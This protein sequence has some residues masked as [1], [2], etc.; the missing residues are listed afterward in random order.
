MRQRLLISAAILLIYGSSL[1]VA[2]A[3]IG[4]RLGGR[5]RTPPAPQ[6]Q[7][8]PGAQPAP[9]RPS[10]Q[11]RERVQ[12]LGGKLLDSGALDGLTGKDGT[13]LTGAL[14]GAATPNL[15][16]NA[17][18]KATLPAG[19]KPFT[20]GWYAAHPTAWQYS[21]PH[22]DAWAVASIGTVAVWLGIPAPLPADA[23]SGDNVFTSQ[24]VAPPAEV[25]EVGDYLPLGVFALG[26]H[27]AHDAS[28]LVQLA[29]SKSGELRGTY[30]DVVTGQE[31]PLSGQFDKQTQLATFKLESPDSAEFEISLVSL[32]RPEGNARLRFADGQTRDWSLARFEPP[33]AAAK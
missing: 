28:A 2:E 4:R 27:G 33:E 9:P 32:T 16:T 18:L 25:P 31:H 24:S 15:A 12:N 10:G 19:E 11:L 7:P 22:A 6:A 3:Q 30:Y 8:A 21:H 13:P 1:A 17:H 14:P 26:P 20:P 23:A 29:V 5:L